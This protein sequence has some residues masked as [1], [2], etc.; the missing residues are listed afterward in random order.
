MKLLPWFAVFVVV[1]F[2]AE[3]CDHPGTPNKVGAKALFSNVVQVTFTNTA[4]EGDHTDMWFM[5]E[6]QTGQVTRVGLGNISYGQGAIVE[7]S[8]LAPN[9]NH[10][11][12]VW[13]RDDNIKGCRS[14]VPSAYA[15]AFTDPKLGVEPPYHPPT[16]PGGPA[17]VCVHLQAGS[18]GSGG[19][20]TPCN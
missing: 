13:S 20:S 11:F 19:P 18:V 15:C 2:G 1:S 3:A 8:A 17:G 5:V 7:V 12:R 16:T 4:R 9:Q 6:E 14:K 10:C